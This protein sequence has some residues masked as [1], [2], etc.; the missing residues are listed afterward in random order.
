MP[1]VCGDYGLEGVQAGPTAT[2]R[3]QPPRVVY[4]PLFGGISPFFLEFNRGA[5]GLSQLKDSTFVPT[6]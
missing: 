6:R 5:K 1:V 2:R 4:P 3:T